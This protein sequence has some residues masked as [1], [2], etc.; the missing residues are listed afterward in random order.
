MINQKVSNFI[1]VL[2][3]I[4]LYSTDMNLVNMI[5]NLDHNDSNH[6]KKIEDVYD[7][8]IHLKEIPFSSDFRNSLQWSKNALCNLEKIQK[9]IQNLKKNDANSFL[10][11]P[12]LGCLHL[13]STVIRNTDEGFSAT[14]IN[15]GLRYLHDPLEEFVFKH[16]NSKNLLYTLDFASRMENVEDVYKTFL[17]SSDASYNLKIHSS[18]QKVGNCFTKNIQAGIKFACA[19]RNMSRDEIKSLRQLGYTPLGTKRKRSTTFKWENL[20]T[21]KAQKLL[22]EDAILKNPLIKAD[23]EHSLEVYIGNKLFREKLDKRMNPTKA[24]LSSFQKEHLIDPQNKDEL[25][26]YAF[27]KITPYTYHKFSSEFFPIIKNL[28]DPKISKAYQNLEKYQHL[29]KNF[30]RNSTFGLYISAGLDPLV[31][32]ERIF[33]P[34]NKFKNY[35]ESRKIKKLI[36]NLTLY[37]LI[38]HQDSVRKLLTKAYGKD[39]AMSKYVEFLKK[40]TLNTVEYLKNV[41]YMLYDLE[42]TSKIFPLVTKDLKVSL[43]LPLSREKFKN[44]FNVPHSKKNPLEIGI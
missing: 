25:I 23:A 4:I 13:W 6:Y 40:E 14:V 41:P 18:P 1:D 39:H 22:V 28:R 20:P 5:L 2:Y 27:K 16:E 44:T 31:S 35:T 36:T 37:N 24:L 3:N 42:K 29:E 17:E 19:T 10:I 9:E 15:K 33:D 43:S 38:R 12:L 11:L 7:H 21:I 34:K 32:L 30:S 26:K 8:Y